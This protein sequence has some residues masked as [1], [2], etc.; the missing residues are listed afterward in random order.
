MAE[1]FD[2]R[3]RVKDFLMGSGALKKAASTGESTVNPS[4]SQ[5]SG[6]DVAKLA[7]EQ[8][9]REKARKAKAQGYDWRVQGKRAEDGKV[10]K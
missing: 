6:I 10:M 9:D 1:G 2:W 7:Q 4:P 5:P 3:T 8:A